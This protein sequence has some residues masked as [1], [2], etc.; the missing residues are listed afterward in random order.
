MKDTYRENYFKD[1]DTTCDKCLSSNCVEEE[2]YK[3]FIDT[4]E[5]SEN[6][7]TRTICY[8]C[9]W[10]EYY[11]FYEE[12]YVSHYTHLLD[13]NTEREIRDLTPLTLEQL[14]MYRE[15]INKLEKYDLMMSLES[16]MN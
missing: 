13:I 2:F 5:Y 12:E 7:T 3:F 16:E 10:T 9:G 4:F 1:T 15:R 14:E 6:T 8:E 11:D